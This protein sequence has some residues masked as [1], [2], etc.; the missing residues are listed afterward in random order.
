M[1][2]NC[3]KVI[4]TVASKICLNMVKLSKGT[5]STNFTYQPQ[6]PK[7]LQALIERQNCCK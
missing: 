2:N 1:A 6:E 7:E 3:K 4:E 5:A